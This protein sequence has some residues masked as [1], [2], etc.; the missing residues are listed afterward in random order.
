MDALVCI[1]NKITEFTRKQGTILK[2]NFSVEQYHTRH[3]FT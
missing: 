1:P 3:S 2:I